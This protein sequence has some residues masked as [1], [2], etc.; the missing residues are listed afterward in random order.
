MRINGEDRGASDNTDRKIR[1]VALGCECLGS[2]MSRAGIGGLSD[3]GRAGDDGEW[4]FLA[5]DCSIIN[6]TRASD[7]KGDADASDNQPLGLG[8]CDLLW[9]SSRAVTTA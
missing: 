2:T 7:N 9:K 5:I 6:R 4:Q 3:D 8:C 1:G